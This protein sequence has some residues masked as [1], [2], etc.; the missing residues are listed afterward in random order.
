VLIN[1]IHEIDLM[2]FVAGEIVSVAALATGGNRGFAVEDTAGVVLELAN[3]ALGTVLISDSAVSPWTTEQGVGESPE[4]P[5]SGQ[6]NYRFLGATGA[7]E[8][9]RLV[10]WEQEG[11]TPDWNKGIRARALFAPTIDPYAAQLDHFR[12]V[13][14]GKTA[15]ML[16]VADAARTLAAT[17]AVSEA[18]ATGRRIDLAGAYER[19]AT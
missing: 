19:L 7:L 5:Y 14:R 15:S 16:T 2:R 6:S 4:F 8:F 9:P 17:L 1:L 3:G 11:R 12:D 10:H 13:V 18:A